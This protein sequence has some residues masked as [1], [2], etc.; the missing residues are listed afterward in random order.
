[1]HSRRL[2]LSLGINLL[3]S[4]YKLCSFNC[5]YCQYGWTYKPTLNVNQHVQDLPRP[6]EISDALKRS[7]QDMIRR[8]TKVD[9]ITFAGNGE[10][11]LHP[12]LA[13]IIDRTR[14]FRDKYVPQAKLAILSNSSTVNKEEVR[15]ALEM[16]DMRVM[17]LDAGSEELMRHLNK[18]APPLYLGEIVDG[19]K[20]LKD[21]ILQSLF[22]QGRL[23]NTDPNSVEH[24]VQM[25][26]EVQP[27][28][29]QVYT[30]DRL[31]AERRLWKVNIPT[32]QWIASQVRWHAGVRAEVF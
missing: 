8:G 16:L 14:L 1:V 3:P 4:G 30:L 15:D 32:L 10:P 29:V 22:V 19:L 5:L 18:P 13:E 7:L 20:K 24:W 23:T 25:V 27:I 17:K 11:T 26:K 31:P 28:L 21:V 6:E 12:E 2:G 9:C